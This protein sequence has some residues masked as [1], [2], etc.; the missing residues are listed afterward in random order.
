MYIY[1]YIYTYIYYVYMYVCVYI[2]RHSYTFEGTNGWFQYYFKSLFD[3]VS[4]LLEFQLQLEISKVI[5]IFFFF[6]KFHQRQTLSLNFFLC[7]LAFLKVSYPFLVWLC[8]SRGSLV[9]QLI[10]RPRLVDLSF[11]VIF[12]EKNLS[13]V[14]PDD[15]IIF[16][17]LLRI[18]SATFFKSRV[19]KIT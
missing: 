17:D 8:Y 4:G 3:S 16:W 6:F 1:I 13:S 15:L 19:Q 14:C 18:F 11:I 2:E 10:V 9:T 12:Y 7:C 5:H